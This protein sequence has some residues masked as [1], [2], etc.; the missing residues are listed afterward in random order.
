MRCTNRKPGNNKLL[1][2]KNIKEVTISQLG[3]RMA[4]IIE[5]DFQLTDYR[6]ADFENKLN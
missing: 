6:K 3:K 2:K 5:N 1:K 4:K